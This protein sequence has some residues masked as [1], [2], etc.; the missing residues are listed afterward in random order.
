[1]AARL[2]GA[3]HRVVVWNRSKDKT[4]PLVRCGAAAAS[5]PAEATANAEVAITMLADAPAV[6]A[7]LTGAGGVLA[8]PP[9]ALIQ[10]S[11]VSPAEVSA[12]A[13]LARS[14]GAAPMQLV[15]APVLGSVPQAQIG[16]LRVLVG[17]PAE[18]FERWRD[19]LAV[20]GEPVRVGPPGSASALKLVLNAAVSPMAALLA[21]SLALADALGLD[22]GLALDEL[23]RSRIGPLVRRK[24]AAIESGHFTADSRLRLFAKDMRLAV[25]SGRA[26][27]LDMRMTAAAAALAETA[28][29]EGFGELDYSVLVAR[30]RAAAPRLGEP[31]S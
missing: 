7:V 31:P 14:G 21:E 1:M 26:L 20:F 23:A 29:A 25:E 28:V 13:E 12:L 18:A 5:T 22:R 4:A 17:A 27:G 19:L 8:A 6:R 10:M 9:A 11:T 30:S 16:G 24:R 2:T 3:G 15:D